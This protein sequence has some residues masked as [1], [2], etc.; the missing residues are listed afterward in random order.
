M[1]DMTSKGSEVSSTYTKH[2]HC[3]SE[4]FITFKNES[5]GVKLFTILTQVLQCKQEKNNKK[6][7]NAFLLAALTLLQETVSSPPAPT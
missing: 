3:D 2:D 6:R 4:V 5:R 7:A 1:L